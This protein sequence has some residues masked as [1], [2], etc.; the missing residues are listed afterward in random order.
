ML[1]P[2][3]RAAASRLGKLKDIP[4]LSYS[5]NDFPSQGIEDLA[6]TAGSARGFATSSPRRSY[7]D[8]IRNILISQSANVSSTAS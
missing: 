5:V 7:E 2:S 3:V 4:L 1:S 8:T 6:D